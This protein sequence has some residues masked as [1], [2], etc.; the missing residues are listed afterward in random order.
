M[1]S[2]SNA[3]DDALRRLLVATAIANPAARAPRRKS[4][5]AALLGFVLAGALTGGAVSTAAFASSEAISDQQQRLAIL[6]A[7]RLPADGALVGKPTFETGA[8]T[9]SLS[10][11][12]KP[13]RANALVVSYWCLDDANYRI[14]AGALRGS[15]F[16]CSTKHHYVP[17]IHE[18][19]AF[20]L[21]TGKQPILNVKI[22][23]GRS[24][25]WAL[26]VSW[27]RIPARQKASMQQ[28]AEVADG[29]VTR[30]E[31][32]VAYSRYQ[33]CMAEAGFP[34]YEV[35][36]DSV[37]YDTGSGGVNVTASDR[38]YDREFSDV[39]ILWQSENPESG[40]DGYPAAVLRYCLTVTGNT[41]QATAEEMLAQLLAL[42]INPADC[43]PTG[44]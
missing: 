37:R 2:D 34:S 43:T 22:A 12:A 36:D 19:D 18:P 3:R 25:E 23:T 38:C 17:G 21:G 31:Y 39:D 27:A 41:P 13:K 24:D 15:K 32:R 7:Y 30:A 14:D 44:N 16:H 10:I 28:D 29:T 20:T 9:S 26:F 4:A 1:N 33:G 5:I 6:A 8:G 11:A 40:G 42:K 35:L